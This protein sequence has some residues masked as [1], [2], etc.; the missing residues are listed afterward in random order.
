MEEPSEIT[1][2]GISS[3]TIGKGSTSTTTNAGS[4]QDEADLHVYFNGGPYFHLR[5]CDKCTTLASY[6]KPPNEWSADFP[7]PAIV[8]CHVGKGKAVLSGVHLEYSA[9]E[10]NREDYPDSDIIEKLTA[11]DLKRVDMLKWIL[12]NRLGL[13]VDSSSA[14][15]R[16]NIEQET[17][18]YLTSSDDIEFRQVSSAFKNQAPN[19]M[20]IK[21]A[22]SSF[23][24]SDYPSSCPTSQSTLNSFNLLLLPPRLS[25]TQTKFNPASFYSYCSSFSPILLFSNSTPSTQTLL[26]KNSKIQDLLPSGS[27]FTSWVQTAGRGR[28]RN[29]W[30]GNEGCLQ[31]SLLTRAKIGPRC[32]SSKNGMMEMRADTVVFLQYIMAL[33]VVKAVRSLI[34]DFPIFIKWPNDVYVKTKSGEELSLKKIGGILVNSSFT[35]PY[36]TF[37][38]GCG[39]NIS[40]A[41]PTISLNQVLYSNPEWQTHFPFTHEQTL[42]LV[43]SK[44]DELLNECIALDGFKDSLLEEYYKYWLH[45]NQSVVL[46]THDNHPAKIIGIDSSGYLVARSTVN[47]GEIFHLSPDGNGFDM[48]RG[49]IVRKL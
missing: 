5:D 1:A 22:A 49:L 25:T 29:S 12:R 19:D 11:S 14:L 17:D 4:E 23:V 48:M 45:S 7:L 34:P 40:N 8:E 13:R 46:E 42:A 6:H 31:F 41:Q 16:K 39:V 28:G 32:Q 36:F 10:L 3:L 15:D 35:S 9:R 21:D 2:T 47:H 26:D 33:A 43:V 24:V 44:F 37:I 20:I 18:I 38:I 27:V 30:V